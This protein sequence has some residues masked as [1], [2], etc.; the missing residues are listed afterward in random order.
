[1]YSNNTWRLFVGFLFFLSF[2]PVA[3]SAQTGTGGATAEIL[4]TIQVASVQDLDF[5]QI[6]PQQ[7]AGTVT[8]S[9]SGAV[10]SSN[11]FVITPGSPGLWNVT[12]LAGESYTITLPTSAVLRLG[13]SANTMTAVNFEHDA[14]ATP[15]LDAAG[16]DSFNVGATLNVGANQ[17][18]GV[19]NG[20]YIVAVAYN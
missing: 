15:T 3:A 10:S 16:T 12:G 9:A 8:V 20:N 1:M 19:Y 6:V 14:G 13:T 5:G 7:V 2:L 4:Q 18:P 11:V 17:T